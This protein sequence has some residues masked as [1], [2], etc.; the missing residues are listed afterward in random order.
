MRRIAICLFA[1]ALSL[2]FA[3]KT[4]EKGKFDLYLNGVSKG[5]DKFKIE[6]KRDV[7][8]FSSEVR[9]QL[10]MAKAKRNYVD[11]FLYPVLNLDAKTGEFLGYKYRMTFNDFS[12]TDLVEADQSAT[13]VIDQ[14]RRNW[15]LLNRSQQRQQ[16]EMANRI[17]LGVNSGALTPE[18][19]V[20]KFAQT[21]FS[22]SRRKEEVLPDNLAIVDDYCFGNYMLLARKAAAMKTE[23][24]PLSI[25]IPQQMGLKKGSLEYM[26]TDKTSIRGEV[27]VLKHYDVL[28]EDGVYASFWMDKAG[29]LVQVVIPTEGLV[30][31]L[32]GYTPRPFERE[33][34]RVQRLSMEV[35]GGFQER[36]V[37][38]DSAGVS[39]G[40]T[41]TLPIGP[42]PY[43]GILLVQD[44]EPLDR[45]GNDPAQPYSKASTWKQLAFFLA[46]QGFATLR[47]DNRG[48]GESGGDAQT[49]L[50][51][52]RTSDVRACASWLAARPEI[53]RGGI[54]ILAQGL[55]SWVAAQAVDPKDVR[56]FAALGFP[57]KSLV[58]LW[59]EQVGGMGDPESR[60]QA[61]QDLD[62]L[63]KE[64]ESG[65]QAYATFRG[66]KVYLPAAR[67]LAASDPAALV[68]ALKVPCLFVYPAKDMVV[69]A[70]HR[71]V[72]KPFLHAGQESM[73]LSGLGHRL[74]QMDSEGPVSGLVDTKALEPLSEWLKAR[75]A[76]PAAP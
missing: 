69:M 65:D 21:R 10:P 58:R 23:S 48:V 4:V 29:K 67:A 12:N 61:Y 44:L 38:V 26:G 42:G 37:H 66:Q 9:F 39:L 46:G 3:A 8:T 57:A 18:G 20:L 25:A 14:D 11:L 22:D 73:E 27:Y 70:F 41:L 63:Q 75:S 28:I 72:L 43:P 24:L 49:A 19:H 40:G 36:P 34:P 16:D 51:S 59:R 31:L 64:L 2:P 47:Y 7:E 76:P 50:P 30:A 56:A 55:G 17:D 54:I 33:L 52:E 5:Y 71:D 15:D 60:Q 53:R 1:A 68:G 35:A 45:D 32:S 13:E 62:M 6:V 74:T